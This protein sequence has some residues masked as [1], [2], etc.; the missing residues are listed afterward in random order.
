M[1]RGALVVGIADGCPYY[2]SPGIFRLVCKVPEVKNCLFPR[3]PLPLC[4]PLRFVEFGREVCP[5]GEYLWLD[6]LRAADET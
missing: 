1:Q 4:K 6:M 3:K 5:A 2:E